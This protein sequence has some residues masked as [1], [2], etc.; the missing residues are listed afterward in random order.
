MLPKS[1]HRYLPPEL[2]ALVIDCLWDDTATLWS[3]ARTCKAWYPRSRYHLKRHLVVHSAAKLRRAAQHLVSPSSRLQ[4]AQ[5]EVLHVHEDR[6]KPFFHTL[7][8]F[9]HGPFLPAL[10]TMIFHDV[11]W[12]ARRHTSPHPRFYSLLCGFSNVTTLVFKDCRLPDF[13]ELLRVACSF[14]QIKVAKDLLRVGAFSMLI[15]SYMALCSFDIT[16]KSAQAT[17]EAGN[18]VCIFFYLAGGPPSPLVAI[19][20]ASREIAEAFVRKCTRETLRSG[21]RYCLWIVHHVERRSL[22]GAQLAVLSLPPSP[23][24]SQCQYTDAKRDPIPFFSAIVGSRYTVC[25][26]RAIEWV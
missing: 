8:F 5:V 14:P 20:S 13:N 9:I 2:T 12:H 3:C 19:I 10:K 6:R 26:R 17:C 4:F 18:G 7:P 1:K 15:T 22:Y 23:T 25:T 24:G 11:G 16:F 21:L